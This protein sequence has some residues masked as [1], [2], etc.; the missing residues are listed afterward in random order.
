MYRRLVVTGPAGSGKSTLAAAAAVRIGAPYIELDAVFW[1]PN[2][3]PTP[4]DIFRDKVARLVAE[5]AWTIGANYT[6]VR[7]VIWARAEALVWLDLPLSLV[8]SR[9]LHR[10]LRRIIRREQL[11][12]GNRETWRDAFF[13]R[14]SLFP[15]AIR[16]HARFRRE[17][18]SALEAPA[19]RHLTTWRL[20]TPQEVE[21]WLAALGD[22]NHGPDRS[23]LDSR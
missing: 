15:F 11:W 8:L 10:T 18:P 7:E 21:R 2:W 14:E 4:R 1:G 6:S 19:N 20:R 22:S 13:S 23:I 9:L 17:L 3:T 16:Q 5:E 12:S